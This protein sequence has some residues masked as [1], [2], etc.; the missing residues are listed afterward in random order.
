[1]QLRLAGGARGSVKQKDSKPAGPVTLK[2]IGR[3]IQDFEECDV[4]NVPAD[5]RAKAAEIVNSNAWAK[6]VIRAMDY[7]TTK[8]MLV[9]IDEATTWNAERIGGIL[10]MVIPGYEEMVSQR[11]QL[12]AS[13]HLLQLAG[14]VAVSKYN[15]GPSAF[16]QLVK[17]RKTELLE[18]IA[19]RSSQDVHHHPPQLPP[20]KHHFQI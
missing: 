10:L 2:K 3:A 7:N 4:S 17:D 18:A 8:K 6:D 14:K 19:A 11:N 12:K 20:K 13:V 16:I 1:M 9:A 5:I 15:D